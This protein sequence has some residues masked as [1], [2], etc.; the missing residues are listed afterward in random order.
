LE[1]NV[2]G[3]GIAMGFLAPN[4]TPNDGVQIITQN[5]PVGTYRITIGT[6]LFAGAFNNSALAISDQ[7]DN[8]FNIVATD[9]S[10]T[11][12]CNAR[13]LYPHPNETFTLA[14]NATPSG[15]LIDLYGFVLVNSDDAGCVWGTAGNFVPTT[16]P[17]GGA[18]GLIS[19]VEPGV[20]GSQTTGMLKITG[21]YNFADPTIGDR[22]YSQH[23]IFDPQTYPAGLYHLQFTDMDNQHPIIIPINIEY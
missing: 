19:V 16:D 13:V 3:S 11:Q 8:V 12:E 14:E 15:N 23:I 2:N 6:P 18:G 20:G 1:I 7:S 22:L 10:L 5:W 9:Q 21:N 17:N 4:G